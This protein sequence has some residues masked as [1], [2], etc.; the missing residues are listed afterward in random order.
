MAI[1]TL[2]DLKRLCDSDPVRGRARMGIGDDAGDQ[3]TDA[4][5]QSFLDAQEAYILAY[6]GFTPVTNA[7]TKEIHGKLTAWHIWIHVIDRSQGEGKIPEYVQKWYDWALEC[8]EQAKLGEITIDSDDEQTSIEA[9]S[10][11]FRQ[12]ID[13]EVTLEHDDYVRLKYWPVIPQ[14]EIVYSGKDKTGTQYTR[15][16]D[17]VIKWRQRE[18]K[19]I[20]TGAIANQQKVYVSYMHIESKQMYKS[21]QRVDYVDRVG[22]PGWDGIFGGSR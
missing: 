18:I 3:L 15:G 12:V 19:A 6:L 21:P 11:E 22:V 4:T 5:A 10:S 14:S 13:E 8:L 20:S 7:L 17:Y 2:T 9:Y 1:A 16:T